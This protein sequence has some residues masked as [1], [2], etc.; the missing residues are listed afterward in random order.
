MNPSGKSIREDL[1]RAKAAYAKNDEVRFLTL[2]AHALKAFAAVKV[3]GPE[4]ITI[5]GLFREVMSIMTKF[6]H[7]SRIAPKGLAYVKG[8]EQA[9]FVQVAALLRKVEEEIRRESLEA[10]RA[11]KLRIDQFVLKAQKFLTEGNILEAQRNFR[12]AVDEFVDEKGLFPLI[13]S[14]LIEAGY[15][16]QSLEYVK[17]AIEEYP[18][19]ARAYDFLLQALSKTGEWDAGEKLLRE[20]GK[21]AAEVPVYLTNLARVL[22]K[23]EN[24]DEAVAAAQKALSLDT[25]QETA[26]KILALAAKRAGAPAA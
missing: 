24:W 18:D 16:K 5:E 26:R 9:L 17:R 1:G 3:F 13:A 6:D 20:A 25:R 23:N 4:R 14:R 21:N 10:M 22:A 19:N 12:A 15:H 2:L 11:R 7:V 8:Q